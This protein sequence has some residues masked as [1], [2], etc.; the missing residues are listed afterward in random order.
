MKAVILGWLQEI[1]PKER[2]YIELFKDMPLK[3]KIQALIS[4]SFSILT[5]L[6]I[7]HLGVFSRGG[8]WE[9]L[10]SYSSILSWLRI[11][12]LYIF[13]FLSISCYGA[14]IL[15]FP[16]AAKVFGYIAITPYFLST[17]LIGLQIGL[18]MG[19]GTGQPIEKSVIVKA[20]FTL[21]AVLGFSFAITYFTRASK[22]VISEKTKIDTAIGLAREIQEQ[23]VPPLERKENYFELYGETISANEIGGDHFDAVSLDDS[24][25][26]VAV[27]DVS[28]HNVS[29]GLLMAVTKTAFETEVRHFR[30]PEVLLEQLNRTVYRNSTKRMFV[31][32]TLGV[33]DFKEKKAAFADAGHPPVLHY[34]AASKVLEEIKPKGPA[35]GITKSATYVSRVVPFEKGD[36][37]LL[38]SDGLIEAR[39]PEGEEF[40]MDN[41]RRL[42]LG[43]DSA[44]GAKDFYRYILAEMK[45]FSPATPPEDDTTI[46]IVRI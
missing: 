44:M 18:S 35:L 10:T 21:L 13:V 38:Y 15:L 24:T 39:S 14:L 4:F 32:F 1:E 41:L 42:L 20:V 5:I 34:K 37:F 40:G 17:V 7:L 36:V 12:F 30:Q 27:G 8:L 22:H 16:H 19:G 9:F 6:L 45:N 43:Y 3:V 29:A 33:F 46:T 28:G 26:A 23:L 31:T 25:L 11:E 2:Y